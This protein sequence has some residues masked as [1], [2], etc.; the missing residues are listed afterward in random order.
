MAKYRVRVTYSGGTNGLVGEY[1]TEQKAF[2][3][4]C[5]F[6]GKEAYTQ[7]E[8]MLPEYTCQ[9]YV[10]AAELEVNLHYD[11]DNS[12]CKYRVEKIK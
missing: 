3:K 7:N 6:A 10:N 11:S 9:I 1:P 4:A 8:E 5:E 2:A 12:W